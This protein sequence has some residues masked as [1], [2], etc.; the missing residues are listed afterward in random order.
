MPPILISWLIASGPKALLMVLA[1]PFGQSVVTLVLN[2]LFGGP[3]KKAKPKR[4]VRKKGRPFRGRLSDSELDDEEID[5]NP[6]NVKGKMGYQS[7]VANDNGAAAADE[8]T[9]DKLQF[10]GWDDLEEMEPPQR[11]SPRMPGR[12]R[13]K[14][15][16]N[17]ELGMSASRS[18]TPLLLRLL[19]AVFPFLGSWTKLF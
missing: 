13:R 6:G 12:S 1:I 8:N 15:S 3:R 5:E 16:E 10:G 9:Q 14:T 7:W 2:K 18:G 19:I 4:K 11:P 17:G